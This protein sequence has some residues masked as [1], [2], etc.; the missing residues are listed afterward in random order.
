LE[1]K[2]KHHFFSKKTKVLSYSEPT[3]EQKPVLN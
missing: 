1:I 2:Y 3:F